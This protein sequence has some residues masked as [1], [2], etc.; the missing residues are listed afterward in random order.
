MK[1]TTA[2]IGQLK[3]PADRK[4]LLVFDDEQTGLGIRVTVG[5]GKSY[6]VQYRHTGEKRRIPVGSCSA[7]SLKAARKA[8]QTIMGD[9][10][11][12]RDPAAE[13]KERAREAK[14]RAERETLRLGAL[15]G[16]WEELHLS[17][18][19]PGYAAEATRALRFAFAKQ[20]KEPAAAL[21][22]NAVRQ[23]INAIADRGKKATARLTMAYGRACYGWAVGRDLVATNPFEDVKAES[24]PARDRVASDDELRAVWR[25]T[26]GPGAYKSIVRLL[27]LTGQ[28]RD[29][30]AG[31]GWGEVSP[32]LSTWTIPASRA[33]NSHAH[34]VPLSEQAQAVLRAA[35][36]QSHEAGDCGLDLVFSARGG[37]FAGWSKAKAQLDEA[38]G[39]K[40]WRIH[41]LRRTVATGLQK[42]GVRLEVT[43]AVL[44][45][46]SGSRAGI[47]GVYQRH[48]WADEK[49]AALN[50][51]GAHVAA[52]VEGRPAEGNV[53]PIRARADA[54]ATN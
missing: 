48:N 13:R 44:N 40:N 14:E 18:K 16:R 51:W 8:A 25:A 6:L 33:K 17:G 46:V 54:K 49:R 31:I 15:V 38:S 41:D 30:V 42:L 47:V 20:L 26:E 39:V 53:T 5:G 28:R 50:A 52:L 22:A 36:R 2:T 3:C 24:V 32:D 23:T 29:E 35:P 12:G 21:E 27:I 37:P 45:H 9:V 10:A 43:E 4:D 1:F 11:K 7:I 19:R 34:T